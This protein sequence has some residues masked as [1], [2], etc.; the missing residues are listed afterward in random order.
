[1]ART[2]TLMVCDQAHSSARSRCC[3]TL[4]P[5]GQARVWSGRESLADERVLIELVESNMPGFVG[6]TS[7]LGAPTEA[8]RVV[9]ALKKK[10]AR[11]QR[12]GNRPWIV[13]LDM[14]GTG[15]FIDE[16]LEEGARTFL[17]GSHSISAVVLQRR[18]L[19]ADG[20]FSFRSRIVANPAATYP[21]SAAEAAAFEL[22][23][24]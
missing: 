23:D 12:A 20:G 15:L 21:L 1:M 3:V 9:T 24:P 14:S 13:A 11:K 7:R 2:V 5:S 19:R 6:S 22:D 18:T 17:R 8:D 4:G 16:E 10:S